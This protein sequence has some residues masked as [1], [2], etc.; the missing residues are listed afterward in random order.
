[1]LKLI[2]SYVLRMWRRTINREY[3]ETRL[4]RGKLDNPSSYLPCVFPEA[5]RVNIIPERP[6]SQVIT[7]LISQDS[8]SKPRRGSFGRAWATCFTWQI[9]HSDTKQPATVR[10]VIVCRS[11]GV[12]ANC[13]AMG[14]EVM[15]PFL[16]ASAR[17]LPRLQGPARRRSVSQFLPLIVP[18][19]LRN[20]SITS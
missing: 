14:L 19:T 6:F 13:S 18:F 5:R 20:H 15:G 17:T 4:V 9:A 11:N 12:R 1:M 8:F 16:A 3:I 2:I 7:D 10:A